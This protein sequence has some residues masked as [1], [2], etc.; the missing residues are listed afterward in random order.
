MGPQ[1]R[2]IHTSMQYHV[3]GSLD[4]TTRRALIALSGH[5]APKNSGRARI[6]AQDPRPRESDIDDGKTSRQVSPV[7]PA[8]SSSSSINAVQRM[9][10]AAQRHRTRAP[11]NPDLEISTPVNHRRKPDALSARTVDPRLEDSSFPSTP[12]HGQQRRS[13]P[14]LGRSNLGGHAARNKPPASL[15]NRARSASESLP[16]KRPPTPL[17]LPAR[18]RSLPSALQYDPASFSAAVQRMSEGERSRLRSDIRR[19]L[20]LVTHGRLASDAKQSA[21]K[22]AR[23]LLATLD[24]K[25]VPIPRE[26]K[27]RKESSANST[28][29]KSAAQQ[30][31]PSKAP[32][33][34]SVRTYSPSPSKYL[35]PARGLPISGG[36]PS[37]GR[38]T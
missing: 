35:L 13:L 5:T 27:R 38:R 23:F 29:K 30:G 10:A 31:T 25:A 28:R 21:E 11:K 8:T 6:E 4:E 2:S 37:L 36:L 22:Q 9:A 18:I 1:R 24:G 32:H 33:F 15:R 19:E 17:T 20:L 26:K 34:K 3:A 12:A 14:P 16:A 7:A